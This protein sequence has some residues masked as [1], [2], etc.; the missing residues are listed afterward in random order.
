LPNTQLFFLKISR[1]ALAV[2][3]VLPALIPQLVLSPQCAPEHS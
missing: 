2:L 1:D 3:V